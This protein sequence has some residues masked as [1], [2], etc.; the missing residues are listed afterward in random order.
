MRILVGFLMAMVLC[1]SVVAA[2]S[3]G[4]AK[5]HGASTMIVDVPH[6]GDAN[7][8]DT[9]GVSFAGGD[10]N[11]PT[12]KPMHGLV[13]S[14]GS[15]NISL[16]YEGGGVAVYPVTVEDGDTREYLKG[17]R[18]QTIDS[19]KTTFTGRIWPQF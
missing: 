8:T 15:G 5:R 12:N 18:I 14:G 6:S 19:A 17:C 9:G 16:V 2:P 11:A 1:V 10:W 3:T 13:L 7:Y 4:L